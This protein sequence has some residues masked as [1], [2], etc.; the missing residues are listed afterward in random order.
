MAS[1]LSLEFIGEG[2]V[3]TVVGLL[4][5]ALVSSFPRYPSVCDV[6]LSVN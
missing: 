6:A 3:P 2:R 1:V 4:S 5:A